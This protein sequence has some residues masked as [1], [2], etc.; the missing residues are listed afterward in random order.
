MAKCYVCQVEITKENETEEHIILNACG[1][2]LKSKD[3][4]CKTHNTEFG[5]NFDSVLAKQTNDLANL[6][7][8][9]RQRGEPQSIKGTLESTGENYYLQYG[10][11]PVMTKPII[12]E[13]IDGNNVRLS[14]TAKDE[15]ELR[16]ILEGFKRSRY[17]NLNV[18]EHIGTANRS[19]SYLN[20]PIQFNSS[21]GGKETFKSITK[22]AINYFIY[23]GGN[24]EFIT[25]LIPYLQGNVEADAVW[26]HYPEDVIYTPE[27]NEVSHIIQVIGNPNEKILYAYIELFNVHNFIVRLSDSYDGPPFNTAYFFDVLKAETLARNTS[28]NYN[29][30]HLIQ[31]FTEKNYKP[32]EKVQQR[33]ERV[34]NIAIERQASHHRKELIGKAINNSIGKYPEGTLITEDIINEAVKEIMKEIQPL[35]FRY[36]HQQK[37]QD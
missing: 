29:R 31:L 6:L 10:G 23:K 11:S 33:F 1:G 20:E 25:H 36:L 15:K 13:T 8:I 24:R 9:K 4:L 7:L 12:D 14:I 27:E 18:E 3:L 30:H 21:V 26:L 28:I 5:E 37:K 19:K 17:P 16:T 35:L 34:M 22:T 2:R 32:F